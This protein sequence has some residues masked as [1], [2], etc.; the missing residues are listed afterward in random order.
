MLSE[1]SVRVS[2]GVTC[3]FNLAAAVLLV[4]TD[5]PLSRIA[6]ITASDSTIHTA[7]AALMVA[8]FGLAYGWMARAQTI[9]RPMIAFGALVKLGAFSLFAALAT[10]GMVPAS[11]ALFAFPDLV[12]AM[13][14]LMWLRQ[15]NEA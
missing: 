1:K 2:L 14:W 7:L 9:D 13:L 4:M 11:F 5:N 3:A 10:V 8:A 12:F 15:A 6:G